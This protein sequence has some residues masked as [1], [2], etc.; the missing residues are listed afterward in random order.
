MFVAHDTPLLAR[1]EYAYGWHHAPA[2]S[3]T[4][5]P[6]TF[7]VTVLRD[8]ISRVPS[9]Y[10]YLVDPH[11]DDGQPF[12]AGRVER[13]R[14]TRGFEAFVR[15]TPTE[16]LLTQ[17]H[18]FSPRLYPGEAADR[19]RRCSAWFMTEHLDQGVDDLNQRLGVALAHRWDRR[20]RPDDAL[21]PPRRATPQRARARVRAPANPGDGHQPTGTPGP[22]TQGPRC[23]SSL[24]GSLPLGERDRLTLPREGPPTKWSRSKD[25]S[26]EAGTSW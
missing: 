20:S 7:T 17:L 9:L 25:T 8:P 14:A 23:R 5:P 1:G 21:V 13:L 11:A 16:D 18:M 26:N 6:E 15:P 24:T 12:R 2:W 4:L 3:M 19:V 10:R 22:L